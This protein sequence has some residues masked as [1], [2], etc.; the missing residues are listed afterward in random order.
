MIKLLKVFCVSTVFTQTLAVV[1]TVA[2]AAPQ[3]TP[4]VVKA[5]F[6]TGS[7]GAFFYESKK[8]MKPLDSATCS[9]TSLSVVDRCAVIGMNMNLGTPGY[10]INFWGLPLKDPDADYEAASG[11]RGDGDYSGPASDADECRGMKAFNESPRLDLVTDNS[12]WGSF[13]RAQD[14][15]GVPLSATTAS[16]SFQWAPKET[17]RCSASNTGPYGGDN[18]NSGLS[19]I[20]RNGKGSS[21][22]ITK[23]DWGLGMFSLVG[24]APSALV[25]SERDTSSYNEFYKAH[26]RFGLDFFPLFQGYQMFGQPTNYGTSAS[27]LWRYPLPYSKMKPYLVGSDSDLEL[28]TGTAANT[29]AASVSQGFRFDPSRASTDLILPFGAYTKS[30]SYEQI[31]LGTLSSYTTPGT[32]TSGERAIIVRS[33]AVVKIVPEIKKAIAQGN[34]QSHMMA[35]FNFMRTGTVTVNSK[36]HLVDATCATRTTTPI[37]SVKFTIGLAKGSRDAASGLNYDLSNFGHPSVD[38]YSTA[39]VDTV[40]NPAGKYTCVKLKNSANDTAVRP[41]LTTVRGI[42]TRYSSGEGA[43]EYAGNK[44]EFR[45]NYWQIE[46]SFQQFLTL[47]DAARQAAP[48]SQTMEDAY[49]VGYN[50]PGNW[51]LLSMSVSQEVYNNNYTTA[52]NMTKSNFIKAITKNELINQSLAAGVKANYKSSPILKNDKLS[53]IG[54]RVLQYS[55]ENKLSANEGQTTTGENL[56]NYVCPT[57]GAVTNLN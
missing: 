37:Y 25:A 2:I 31:K 22:A 4:K 53:Y 20:L 3:T 55:I 49:G 11:Y 23:K 45:K 21:F 15:T 51:K 30:I 48:C 33:R 14:L 39:Y 57:V 34:S 13:L 10:R 43:L 8:P 12:S 1:L 6:S 56:V 35:G 38:P 28:S 5:N 19:K 52:P 44:V 16:L 47:L 41:F 18:G 29:R 7:G 40:I 26:G 32:A 27:P 50:V 36:S 42:G 24:P 54:G 17:T 46:M 9:T